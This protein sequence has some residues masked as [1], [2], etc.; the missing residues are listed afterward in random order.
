MLIG[1]LFSG[2]GGLE[3]GL[4][5]AGLGHVVWQAEIDPS[6]RQVLARH[7]PDAC[8]L[9]ASTSFRRWSAAPTRAAVHHRVAARRGTG[10][11]IQRRRRAVTAVRR[12]ARTRG[13]CDR[14]TGRRVSTHGRGTGRRRPLGTGRAGPL[15]R[16]RTPGMRA[17][18]TRW[19]LCGRRREHRMGRRAGR[20]LGTG[21]GACT[22]RRKRSARVAA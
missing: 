19:R 1:S 9:A 3:L 16:R 5:R 13:M 6:C 15:H 2:I 8:D 21:A 7:W 22:C 4:E 10:A 12:T 11:S 18:S 20:T 17:R 14:R